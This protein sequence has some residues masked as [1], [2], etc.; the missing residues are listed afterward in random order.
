MKSDIVS[1]MATSAPRDCK[2]L[3][4]SER[5]RNLFLARP[6][7]L[8]DLRDAASRLCLS[9]RTLCRK[10][11]CEG[12]A[13][14][15]LKDEFRLELS[16]KLLT[17]ERRPPKVVAHL[18]GFASPSTFARAFKSWTGLTVQQAIRAER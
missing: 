17:S 18:V 11:E 1:S 8:P 6:T 4:I 5:I 3:L 13:F 2:E 10:L 12:I 16:R 9:E 14:Q 15:D 7:S